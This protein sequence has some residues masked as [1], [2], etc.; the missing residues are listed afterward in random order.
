MAGKLTN[1]KISPEVLEKIT[2]RHNVTVSEV[3]HAFAN[4]IKGLLKDNRE[5]HKTDPPT[6]WFV[7]CTNAGR[8]LKIVY[9]QAGHDIHL[10]SAFDPNEDEKRIYD[11]Y[12]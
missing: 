1:L 4:R 7:A 2:K 11:K 5:Q 9:I 8:L 10:K 6:L 12:A 3:E